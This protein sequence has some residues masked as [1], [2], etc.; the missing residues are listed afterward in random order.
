MLFTDDS[1]H[2]DVMQQPQTAN[3]LRLPPSRAI[4]ALTTTQHQ[5]ATAMATKQHVQTK[6]GKLIVTI[7]SVG[8]QIFHIGPKRGIQITVNGP[9]FTSL[10]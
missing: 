9:C 7:K 6:L 10:H 4:P 3:A 2:S 5:Q 1:S 8:G